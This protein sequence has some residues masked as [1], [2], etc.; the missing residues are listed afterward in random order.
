MVYSENIILNLCLV[1]YR[2]YIIL[3]VK[4]TGLQTST[5]DLQQQIQ[6]NIQKTLVNV[7]KS[8]QEIAAL[9]QRITTLSSKVRHYH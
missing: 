9:K 6:K 4:N 7:T 3:I 8:P 5:D 2:F 1:C